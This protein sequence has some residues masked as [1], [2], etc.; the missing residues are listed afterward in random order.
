MNYINGIIEYPSPA[1]LTNDLQVQRVLMRPDVQF[2]VLN[3]FIITIIV[4]GIAF[5]NLL[6]LLLLL[7]RLIVVLLPLSSLLLLLLWLDVQ[8]PVLNGVL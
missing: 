1:C 3:G 5:I 2:P 4:T 8:F 6:I 7:I